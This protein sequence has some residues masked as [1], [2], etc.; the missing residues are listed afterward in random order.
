MATSTLHRK[1]VKQEFLEVKIR[2]GE[3]H[4]PKKKT[5]P[6]C[7]CAIYRQRKIM[8]PKYKCSLCGYEFDKPAYTPTTKISRED[9]NRFITKYDSQIGEIV[10]Q[11][12]EGF[13]K[14]YK[15]LREEDIMI[16]CR[17]CHLALHKGLNLCPVCKTHYKKWGHSMCWECFKKTEE[18]KHVAEAH[19]LVPYTHPWCGEEFMIEK[20]FWGIAANPHMCCLDYCEKNIYYCEIAKEHW[21]EDDGED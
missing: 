20:G 7:G 11:Q 16:L 1:I 14:R 21:E 9:W 6:K 15:E 12:R 2:E 18:G 3:F 5:C 13:Y 4:P 10:S 19:T 8:T 17:R